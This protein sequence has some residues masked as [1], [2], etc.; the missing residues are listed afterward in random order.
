[1]K[2]LKLYA[3]R[4][5]LLIGA[6]SIALV[7]CTSSATLKRTPIISNE[8]VTLE[9]EMYKGKRDAISFI[10]ENT[11]WYGTG[12]GDLFRTN[13]AGTTWIKIASKPGTFV[14]ALAFQDRNTGYIG[15]IGTD[16]YP[17]VTDETPLYR[18]LDGGATWTAVD[19]R[20]QTIK[21]VC[22]IHILSTERIYQ[23]NILPTSIIHAGGRVGGP[24]GILRSLDN[25]DNWSVI[26]MSGSAA[27]ILDI[28]FF[29]EN[30]GLVFA[31]TS[32]DISQAEGLIL[33]TEDG[34]QTWQEVYRS[35]RKGELVW[36]ASFPDS[37]NG[38][39][40]IQSYDTDRAQ[41]IIVKTSDQG[42]NWTEHPLVLT[43]KARQFGIGFL[44]KNHGWVGTFEGGFYTSDGGLSFT[45]API[46]KGANK[47]Q[48]L[49]EPDG[50]K[51]TIFAIG[52]QVQK[53][54]VINQ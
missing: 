38:F 29:S 4:E 22:A 35:G 17:G 39:A 28:V 2:T 37:Q 33:R 27:M 34:G 7:N 14:R 13:D 18:T 12:K 54:E 36:K 47:F 25:G 6:G 8:W 23:G 46:A 24:T 9:T 48:I 3:R 40:T 30:E 43:A 49:K 45:P 11:G 5:A 31:S 53:L 32:T 20:D 1:M 10:D 41:Q 50:T 15:N 44:D 16:Y 19:L 26:D 52:T 42:K 51:S 21:G